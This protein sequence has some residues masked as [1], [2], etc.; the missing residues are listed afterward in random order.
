VAVTGFFT[1]SSTA[2]E[3]DEKLYLGINT[4]LTMAIMLLMIS[5]KMP[6][7]S[8]YIPLMGVSQNLAKTQSK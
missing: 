7:T 3:R 2:S 1:P 5:N 4:L 6:N 8:S